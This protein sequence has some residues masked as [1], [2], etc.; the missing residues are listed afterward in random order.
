MPA[1]LYAF[2]AS[3]ISS[4]AA[5]LRASQPCRVFT[6]ASWALIAARSASSTAMRWPF[7][8]GHGEEEREWT[9]GGEGGEVWRLVKRALCGFGRGRWGSFSS[10]MRF[11]DEQPILA[12]SS[13]F[14]LCFLRS[15]FTTNSMLRRG[16]VVILNAF[17]YLPSL[18]TRS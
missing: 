5:A 11:D 3:S 7:V 15:N 6:S 4:F 10:A 16:K 2:L 1:L 17:C 12:S 18:E 14:L 9:E 13:C 8:G